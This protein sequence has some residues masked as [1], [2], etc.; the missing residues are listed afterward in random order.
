MIRIVMLVIVSTVASLSFGQ[1]NLD[2]LEEIDGYWKEKGESQSYTGRYYQKYPNGDTA[3]TGTI[4]AGLW[5]GKRSV[6]YPSGV[7]K[8]ERNYKDGLKDGTANDYYESGK[9][10]QVGHY[11]DGKEEGTWNVLFETG[12]KLAELNVQAGVQQGYQRQYE[13]DG[14]LVRQA[15]CVDGQR[16]YSPEFNKL[17]DQ[18]EELRVK[19]KVDE[20][21]E[22]YD[23]AIELNPT[24][25]KAYYGRGECKGYTRFEESI[26][27]YDKCIEIDQEYMLAYRNRANSKI[28]MYTSKGTLSLTYEQSE[29]ACEDLYKAKELGDDGEVS[30][31]L[32]NEHCKAYGKKRKKSRK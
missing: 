22:L 1:I 29:S 30:K 25:A 11:K 24:V 3:A 31:A 12:E 20:A 4:E 19:Y 7:I 2:D 8:A 32:L 10:K 13:K 21:I 28:N 15:Y 26:K 23:K 17:F 14:T 18:A 6:Y 9:L 27:D 16:G 5:K